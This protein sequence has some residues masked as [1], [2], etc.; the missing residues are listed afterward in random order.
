MIKMML[1]A[2]AGGF[3]GTCL[4]YLTARLCQ[5][6][7]VG[8]FPLATFAVNVVG[9]FLIGLLYGWV[10]RSGA[11]SPLLTT[12]FIT[13]FC[14]GYTTFSSFAND[15]FTLVQGRHWLVMGLYTLL[16]VVSGVGM[17]W[18]GRTIAK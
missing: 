7:V 8:I 18:L 1:V 5:L 16:S 17:V 14:G 15:T 9:S 4:R 13:G 12:L 6:L 2:G 11:V 3:I 10:E